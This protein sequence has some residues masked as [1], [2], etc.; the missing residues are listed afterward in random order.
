ME[1]L[2]LLKNHG[3]LLEDNK[4]LAFVFEL[5]ILIRSLFIEICYY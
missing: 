4:N 1:F 3:P 5:Q 2:N